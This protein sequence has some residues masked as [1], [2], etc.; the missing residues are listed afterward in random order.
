MRLGSL[1]SIS[2][3]YWSLWSPRA[4][5]LK[6]AGFSCSGDL[7]SITNTT[8]MQVFDI[9]YLSSLPTGNTMVTD[10]GTCSDSD[11]V[12]TP[13]TSPKF[14]QLPATTFGAS[15][16]DKPRRS[17]IQP[18]HFSD[19][20]L[21]DQGERRIRVRASSLYSRD[22][23]GYSLNTTPLTLDF[24]SPVFDYFTGQELTNPFK[25]RGSVKDRINHWNSR[26]DRVNTPPVPQSP[27]P[28]SLREYI[29]DSADQTDNEDTEVHII[30]MIKEK[31]P[32]REALSQ[33][34]PGG[35]MWI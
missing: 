27:L 8:H 15:V 4:L 22:T 7:V 17:V 24:P 21:T 20:P 1:L 23:N 28:S 16:Q 25:G 13:T 30:S 19:L 11:T 12:S 10:H 29:T 9:S 5:F 3:S 35:A 6:G 31:E 33:A 2:R 32:P 18:E 26:L 34:A 14:A